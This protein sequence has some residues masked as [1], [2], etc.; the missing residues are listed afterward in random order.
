MWVGQQSLHAMK[1]VNLLCSGPRAC[2]AGWF[3]N[4]ESMFLLDS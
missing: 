3:C 4:R 1:R 2:T